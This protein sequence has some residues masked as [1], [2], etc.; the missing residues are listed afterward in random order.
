MLHSVYITER[1]RA[2]YVQIN[3]QC[4][5]TLEDNKRDGLWQ[6]AQLG[7]VA[8]TSYRHAAISHNLT[9]FLSFQPE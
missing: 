1:K 4:V 5:A 3:R 6:I 8:M 2:A 9:D 7:T